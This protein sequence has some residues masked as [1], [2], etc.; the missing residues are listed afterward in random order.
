MSQIS[1]S[2]FRGSRDTVPGEISL[3]Q[4]VQLIGSDAALKEATL[5]HREL[6]RL[7]QDSEADRIKKSLPCM[8]VAVAFS[9]GKS[10]SHVAAY[11][12]VSMVDIDHIPDGELQRIRSVVNSDPHTLLSFV[13]AS[14]SG[15]RILFSFAFPEGADN[16]LLSSA[17]SPAERERIYKRIFEGG[18]AYYRQL[19]GQ[20]TDKSCCNPTRLSFLAHDEAVYCHPEAV[21]LM[22]DKLM[23]EA[24]R[25]KQK[26]RQRKR[27]RRAT[28][29]QAQEAVLAELQKRGVEYTAGH[30]NEYI[31]QAVYLMNRYGVAESE[32]EAWA[33]EQFSDYGSENVLSIVRSCYRQ[34]EEHGT[35]ALPRK[36]S[37]SP[38]AGI[39]EIEQFLDSQIRLRYN[40]IRRQ[41]EMALPE[42][43]CWR[44]ITDRDENTLW[45]RMC[46]SGK[47]VRL[48]DMCS[49][50]HSEFVPAYN[51]FRAYFDSLPVWDGV[52][53]YI[54]RLARTVH[55][56]GDQELFVRHF[57][58]WFVGMLPALLE[59]QQVNHEIMVFIG[60]QGNYKST[61]F[62]RLLP[63]ELQNYFYTKTN[64]NRLTKDDLLTLSEFALVCLEEIDE[65]RPSE[66][67]QLKAM[68]TIRSINERA[69]YGRNK[70]HRPHI[71]SF[72]GTGNNTRF[73]T[74]PTGNRRWLAAEVLEI[75]DPN[76]HPFEYTGLY[77]QALALWKGGFRY[78]FDAEEIDEL[79]RHNARFEAPNLEEE[80]ILT[81]YRKPQEGETGVFVT[82]A[83]I[84]ANINFGLK[85]AL[86]PVKIG[87]VMR[88]LG[89]EA[90]RKGRNLRGYLVV[91]Y[92][93]DEINI[94][95]RASVYCDK[96]EP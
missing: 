42:S 24:E 18:N 15:V 87:L 63:P 95:K 85:Q 69:A 94:N 72:C 20:E 90:V 58:K 65:M 33:L 17:S 70:E 88:K 3:Q 10:R 89:F 39:R 11:R 37:E 68:V 22:A 66:L 47:R 73:L 44:P 40:V 83:Q 61:F 71:A 96:E 32:A 57:R 14:G 12:M 53:D 91:E 8:A 46:K 76:R 28:A 9:G 52:T 2:F 51:P 86:S 27:V 29:E 36:K 7:G 6:K 5:R 78:W 56:R 82:V 84:L 34:A 13:T 62:A 81:Y 21:P 60:R 16:P 19:T 35:R 23:A 49:V 45:C 55:V 67:N 4:A 41:C 31:M 75:D 50:I 64:N 79:N 59:E 38:W 30:H 25:L 43:D 80:L 48:G 54:G 74:D 77:S 93:G 1:F 26:P 92:S